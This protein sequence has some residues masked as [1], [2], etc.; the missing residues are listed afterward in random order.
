MN[1]SFGKEYKLCSK[2]VIDELFE[3]GQRVNAH[4]L[5]LTYKFMDKTASKTPFQ[6]VVSVPKRLFK[7]AVDR[8]R[9]KRLIRECMRKNKS[10]L[11]DF[12]AKEKYQNQQLAL[13]LVYRDNKEPEY[14]F[15]YQKM[16]K[17]FVTLI[18]TIE[19]NE[20]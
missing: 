8:N 15:L 2:K 13:F 11:E 9:I 16:T 20:K 4:P 1:Q 6:V 3:S 19:K 17:L 10:I 12:L 14:Q 7:H 5:A 18:T